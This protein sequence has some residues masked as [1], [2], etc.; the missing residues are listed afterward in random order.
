MVIRNNRRWDDQR[1][2][3]CTF[4]VRAFRCV[5]TEAAPV[6]VNDRRS[7][8]GVIVFLRCDDMDVDATYL[9]HFNRLC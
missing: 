8:V 5:E 3:R 2:K 1:T 9:S 7:W 4:G 6:D